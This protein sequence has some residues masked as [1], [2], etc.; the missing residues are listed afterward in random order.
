M[1][2]T[3]AVHSRLTYDGGSRIFGALYMEQEIQRR[4]ELCERAQN[5]DWEEVI[6]LAKHLDAAQKAFLREHRPGLVKALWNHFD[7]TRGQCGCR[8]T[9]HE[10]PGCTVGL[11]EKLLLDEQST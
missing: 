7:A 6:V 4:I 3:V 5:P 10:R 2:T 8:S 9:S 11:I 1:E